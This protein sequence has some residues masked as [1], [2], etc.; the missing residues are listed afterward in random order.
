M[1]L[2]PPAVGGE[3]ADVDAPTGCDDELPGV[4]HLGCRQGSHSKA[5]E[6]ETVEPPESGGPVACAREVVDEP[7]RVGPA[8]CNPARVTA[9]E[10]R[11]RYNDATLAK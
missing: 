4:G 1:A 7:L 9:Y 5:V 3:F 6:Q 2:A 8:R 11:L 10:R